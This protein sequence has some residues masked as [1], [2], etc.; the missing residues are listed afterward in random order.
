MP[1]KRSDKGAPA[2]RRERHSAADGGRNMDVQSN[3]MSLPAANKLL[4]Y[5]GGGKHFLSAMCGVLLPDE[6][7]VVG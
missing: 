2:K 7:H 4:M 6:M 1:L 5:E 3:N